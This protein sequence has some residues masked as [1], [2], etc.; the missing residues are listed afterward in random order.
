[1]P[2]KRSNLSQSSYHSRK[3][4]LTRSLETAEERE[5]R[6][7]AVREQIAETRGGECSMARQSRLDS[8]RAQSAKSRSQ[9]STEAHKMRLSL[10]RE[11]HAKSRASETFTQRETRL[12]SQR[13]RT[14][15]TRSSETTEARE[16]R[17]ASDRRRHAESLA[18]ET[19]T[20]RETR[21]SSQ[22]SRTDAIRSCESAVSREMRLDSDRKRHAESLAS[23]TY[24]QRETRLSWQRSRT[25][26]A[27]S[28]E[29]AEVRQVRLDSDRERHA[30]SRASETYTQRETRLSSQRSRTDAARSCESAEVRQV[31]LD[32]DRERHAESRASETY[33][34]RET[35]LSSQ[36]SRT[37]A[38]RSHESIEAREMRLDIDRE[39]HAESRASETFTQRETRL[40]SQRSHASFSRSIENH[41]ERETRLRRDRSQHALS[42]SLE[43]DEQREERRAAARQRYQDMRGD[44][45]THLSQER[46][47]I[48]EFRG[49]WSGEQWAAQGE[50]DRLRRNVSQLPTSDDESTV[51]DVEEQPWLNKEGSGFDYNVAIH[52]AA[53]GDIGALKYRHCLSEDFLRTLRRATEDEVEVTDERVLNTCLSSLQDVVISIG[54]NM[55]SEYGLPSPQPSPHQD[56][57]NREYTAETNYDPVVMATIRNNHLGGNA[58]AQEFSDVLLSLGEGTLPEER[59]GQV[60]LPES[61]GRVVSSL[62]ELIRCVYGDIST[63]PEE[64]GGQVVLPES[65]GRVVSSLEELIRCVFEW[66]QLLLINEPESQLHVAG[67]STCH[68][69]MKSFA[70]FLKK[71]EILYTPWDTTSDA[72]LNYTENLKFYLGYKYTTLLYD[73]PAYESLVGGSGGYLMAATIHG[74]ML[75]TS[76][77]VFGWE[78]MAQQS[79]EDIFEWKQLLLINEPES[80]LHVAGKSTCHLMMKSFANFLKK[81]E[82]LYTPWDTTS[83]AGLNYTENLK[84]YL[85]YKYTNSDGVVQHCFT[86]LRLTKV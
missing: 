6:L 25:D 79:F 62:E 57:G 13:S 43:T 71:E 41:E 21:L 34:Q 81:E 36:R 20:Q 55:L 46:D 83:D 29:S 72:G 39:R 42:R 74:Y 47:R 5:A 65:L 16:M 3:R 33:T 45:S 73:T 18:S 76:I 51:Y 61:L 35:R 32:S 58:R 23:E 15:A 4:R 66:K 26:A 68:L 7:T 31:R 27:R 12:D 30:E 11:R 38:A 22:R 37:D 77:E 64:R 17:Q 59:G 70:N 10:D 75:G 49:T 67:K 9:E 69:M 8:M 24:T 84:F 28:C 86:I 48:Q 50:Q 44:A 2:R 82:I 19:Y 53:H 54:G 80:Q 63:L 85:G 60:V 1:M 56:R 78:M 40:S 52:Y 14:D